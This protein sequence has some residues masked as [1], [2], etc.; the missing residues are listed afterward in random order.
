MEREVGKLFIHLSFF[1]N[2]E[3]WNVYHDPVFEKYISYLYWSNVG[4][5]GQLANLYNIELK[6]AI[7][8]WNGNGFGSY[9]S[10]NVGQPQN[11]YKTLQKLEIQPFIN[12]DL[13]RSSEKQLSKFL[14]KIP[15]AFKVK[16]SDGSAAVE[17][18]YS[19]YKLITKIGEGYRPN[20]ND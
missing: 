8:R 6:E 20:K 5:T 1:L 10:L 13:V 17:L 4:N 3:E 7:Y 14:L 2:K 11:S 12:K 18:D 15:I 16:N 9:I 19:L